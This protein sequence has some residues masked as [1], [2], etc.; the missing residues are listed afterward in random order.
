MNAEQD[1]IVKIKRKTM[2]DKDFT[3]ESYKIKL[4]NPTS[5]LTILREIFWEVDSSLGFYDGCG[6][7]KCKGCHLKVDGKVELACTKIILPSQKEIL[8]E[9]TNM[10]N[11]IVDLLTY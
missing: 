10:D 6:T 1:N 7:G 11:V 9:P 3:Y 2:G 5:V 8:L 4:K